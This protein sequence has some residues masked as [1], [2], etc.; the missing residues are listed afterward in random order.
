[1]GQSSGDPGKRKS[2]SGE[3]VA[4]GIVRMKSL[5]RGYAWWSGIDKTK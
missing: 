5:I 3:D 4:R 2:E 1:M